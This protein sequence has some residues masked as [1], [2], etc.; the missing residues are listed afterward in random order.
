MLQ[1]V[2]KTLTTEEDF[3][4]LKKIIN[5]TKRLY[6]AFDTETT[7][8]NI[9]LDTPFLFQFGFIDEIYNISIYRSLQA[10]F[11]YGY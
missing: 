11:V 10:I 2:S 3:Q 4:E 7:G 9:G 8:L 1:W 6:G 5:K